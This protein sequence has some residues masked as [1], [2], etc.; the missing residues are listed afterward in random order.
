MLEVYSSISECFWLGMR[1]PG[2][3]VFATAGP[4]GFSHS[5]AVTGPIPRANLFQK[6]HFLGLGEMGRDYS[7]EIYTR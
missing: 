3:D 4:S 6:N 5:M 2:D 1:R 7:I